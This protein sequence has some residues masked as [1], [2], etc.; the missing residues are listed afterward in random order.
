MPGPRPDR[1]DWPPAAG[2]RGGGDVKLGD[3]GMGP[4][5]GQT[6]H[7]LAPEPALCVADAALVAKALIAIFE[8]LA[9]ATQG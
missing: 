1:Q 3:G 4:T 8:R 7:R 9:A 5:A 6:S 2:I